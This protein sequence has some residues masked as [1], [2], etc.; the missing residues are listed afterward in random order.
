[1]RTTRTDDAVVAAQAGDRRALESLSATHLPLVYSIV[2]RALGPH[3]DVDDVVQDVMVR[4]LQKLPRLRKP[5]TFRAW[6]VTITIRQ[7]G[8]HLRRQD[9]SAGRTARITEAVTLADVHSPSEDLTALRVDLS[10]QRQQVERATRWL[11]PDD[12]ALL[13][14]WWLEV[15]DQLSRAELASALGLSVAHAGVRLQRMRGH[16]DANRAL[17]AALEQRPRCAGLAA[18]TRTWDG[19]PS[20]LWRKRLTRHV[21]SCP[22]CTRT[23][24]AAVA[25]E[26][27]FPTF[28]LLTVPAGLGLGV[29]GKLAADGAAVGVAVPA[30]ASAGAKAGLLGQLVQAAALH[31][32]VSTVAAGA[33]V[34][35]AGVTTVQLAA[36]PPPPPAPQVV[37]APTRTTARTAVPGTPA[38]ASAP[39][40]RA[41]TGAGSAT[42]AL[43][44]LS[45][46]SQNSP[47]RFVAAEKGLGVLVKATPATNVTATFIA[48]PGLADS[49][50]YSFRYADGR[51]LRHSSWRL[52]LS[53]DQ[54]TPLF[55][56]DA[57]FCARPGAAPGSVALE[58]SN[59]P[60]W[61]LRHRDNELWVDQTD[62][63]T[64]FRTDGSFRVRPPLA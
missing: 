40:P 24:A 62:G 59:Y 61:F 39:A 30:A 21:R 14:L 55:R 48:V 12:R 36:P 37:A 16:L 53:P 20:P 23:S 64:A 47:G 42:V 19:T 33:L 10:R 22:V 6:L 56:G 28:A 26:R 60:G 57:T 34:A 51:F 38:S 46:E 31:P 25:V 52:R 18:E 9:R 58:S 44:P 5:D 13:S 17:T 1:M 43:G 15:A 29:L 7:V 4:A 11:D 63:S 8:T 45:L 3:P 50:C 35:G 32:L 27:L 49:R 2:R 54:R 41:S